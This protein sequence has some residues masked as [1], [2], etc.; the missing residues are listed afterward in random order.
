MVVGGVVASLAFRRTGVPDILFL[1]AL[2]V[3]LGPVAGI[4]DVDGLRSVVPF[5]GAVA[6]VIILFDGGLEIKLRDLGEGVRAGVFL[7]FFVFVATAA[8][9]TLVGHVVGGF[10]WANAALLG[11][12][13]GG[14]GVLIVI[15][16]VRALG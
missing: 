14:A 10:P 7:A 8:S 4:V 15:P 2:G 9:C 16:L 1:I 12:A 11:M 5:V 3:L 13:F 6:I